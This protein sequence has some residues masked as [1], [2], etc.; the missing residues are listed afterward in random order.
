MTVIIMYVLA[1]SRRLPST[2]QQAVWHDGPVP[3]SSLRTSDATTPASVR[4]N[5]YA[6]T[7]WQISSMS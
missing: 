6:A 7:N 3:L 5:C 2:L 1:T 4:P